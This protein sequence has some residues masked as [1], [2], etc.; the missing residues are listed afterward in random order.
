MGGERSLNEALNKTM[1]SKVAKTVAEPPARLRK[2]T[3]APAG[4]P[5]IS[6]KRRTFEPEHSLKMYHVMDIVIKKL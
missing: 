4:T 3:K 5:P 1:R 6:P 2:V